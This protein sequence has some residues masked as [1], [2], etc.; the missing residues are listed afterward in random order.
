MEKRKEKEE[1]EE[2]QEKLDTD[3]LE[4]RNLLGYMPKKHSIEKEAITKEV[5]LYFFF[6]PCLIKNIHSMIKETNFLTMM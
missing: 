4:I 1:N 5:I 2:L 3:Y 6:H